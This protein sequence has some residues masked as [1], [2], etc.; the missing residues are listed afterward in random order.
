MCCRFRI[1]GLGVSSSSSSLHTTPMRIPII[2]QIAPTIQHRMK[3][4]LRPHQRTIKALSKTLRL[5]RIQIRE[6]RRQ[7]RIMR[8]HAVA[9][10][11]AVHVREER[12]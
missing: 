5:P 6:A 3:Q 2:I 7:R 4:N 8:G 12:G 9:E 11:N 10:E 1:G